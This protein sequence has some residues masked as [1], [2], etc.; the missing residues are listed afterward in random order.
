MINTLAM[1]LYMHVLGYSSQLGYCVLA[2]V[3]L[4][5]HHC[6]I[7]R[8]QYILEGLFVHIQFVYILLLQFRFGH[9]LHKLYDQLFVLLHHHLGKQ[10][11]DLNQLEEYILHNLYIQLGVLVVYILPIQL[12]QNFVLVHLL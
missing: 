10:S 1:H 11:Q 5:L 12:G 9:S 3:L 4:H 6:D 7:L 8:T 2:L